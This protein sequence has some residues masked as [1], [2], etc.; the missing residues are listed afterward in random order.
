MPFTLSWIT[1]HSHSV[2]SLC[3]FYFSKSCSYSNRWEFQEFFFLWHPTFTMANVILMWIKGRTR[4]PLALC[5]CFQFL[6]DVRVI[7]AHNS[8][9]FFSTQGSINIYIVAKTLWNPNIADDRSFVP[10]TLFG[11][12]TCLPRTFDLRKK[13]FSDV[14][15]RITCITAVVFLVNIRFGWAMSCQYTAKVIQ[16]LCV[17][18]AHTHTVCLLK[19]IRPLSDQIP[20]WLKNRAA[21]FSLPSIESQRKNTHYK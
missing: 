11:I 5:I 12:P 19:N 4:S 13:L 15:I 16:A 8:F 1:K 14:V 7:F 3:R 2:Q 17:L 9:S 6:R 10:N 18:L 20:D 21:F